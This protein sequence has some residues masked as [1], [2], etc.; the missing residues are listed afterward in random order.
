MMNSGIGVA[1]A[2][3]FFV[4]NELEK[5]AC[6]YRNSAM[7]LLHQFCYFMP[8][9][10]SK[11][12]EKVNREVI[13]LFETALSMDRKLPF[14][15]KEYLEVCS[16]HGHV[17]VD[18]EGV[19][20]LPEEVSI[21]CRKHLV[22]RKIGNMSFGIP[23]NF[24]YDETNSGS[25]DH[26]YDGNGYGGHDYYVYAAVFEGRKAEFK[27]QWFEQGKGPDISD[28]DVGNAKARVA[29]YEPEEKEG[30]I[31]YGMSAQV[32]YKEQRM[33]INIVSRRPGERDWALGLIKNIKITE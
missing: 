15:K 19:T 28:F 18:L 13:E 8:S 12:D 11:Q 3:D 27:N 33:N 6:F 25:M 23:G 24:L 2:R 31:R 20:P 22:Y 5:D 9:D 21:G 32:L 10:R 30:E 16:L 26:Y 4:W 17:P 29:F 14:P 7:V 1:F